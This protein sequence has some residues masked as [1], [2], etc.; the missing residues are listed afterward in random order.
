MIKGIIQNWLFID[1]EGGKQ[2]VMG[3]FN[4]QP[5]ATSPVRYYDQTQKIVHTESGSIYQLGNECTR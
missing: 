3:S 2:R 4:G 1:L 5:I